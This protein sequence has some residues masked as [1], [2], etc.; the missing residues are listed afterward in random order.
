[1]NN[2][3]MNNEINISEP[4][5]E[6]KVEVNDDEFLQIFIEDVSPGSRKFK[7]KIILKGHNAKCKVVGRAQSFNRDKKTWIVL[8]NVCRRNQ[9][10][11]IDLHGTA[12]NFSLLEFDGSAVV[13][14]KSKNA[15]VSINEKI[16]LFDNGQG[17]VNPVLTV[18]TDQVQS[19]YHSA[20]ITPIDSELLFFIES[21]G[22]NKMKSRA[23]IKQ[24]F[25]KK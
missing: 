4:S 5:G 23:L 24:G 15:V 10:V 25:L 6:K 18:K 9:E 22:I 19:A 13:D 8:Q 14:A 16:W 3:L 1:M 20:S 2:K 12:E 11:V 7:L 17:K 21:R